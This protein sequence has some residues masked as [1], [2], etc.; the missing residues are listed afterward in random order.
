MPDLQSRVASSKSPAELQQG[1][2]DRVVPS[3]MF[4]VLTSPQAA[5]KCADYMSVCGLPALRSS[6]FFRRSDSGQV[7]WI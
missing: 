3:Q 1:R 6:P 4:H 5:E 7:N 2:C